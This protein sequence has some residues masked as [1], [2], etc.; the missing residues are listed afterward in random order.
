MS[1]LLETIVSEVSGSALESLSGSLGT[2]SSKTEGAVATALPL[3][4][5]AMANNSSESSGAEAL[6]SAL[7]RDHDGSALEDIAGLVSSD[8]SVDTGSAILKHVLGSKTDQVANGIAKSAGLDKG[9]SIALIAK[10]APVVMGYL[11]KK[12]REDNLDS[13]GLASLLNSESRAA[14]EKAPSQMGLLGKLLDSNND[15]DVTDELVDMGGS[16]LKSFLK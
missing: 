4:I 13:S 9:T 5:K 11:G 7:D 14:E 15:G 1:Q 10:L 6:S 8:S 2:E 16:L 12:K 3:L